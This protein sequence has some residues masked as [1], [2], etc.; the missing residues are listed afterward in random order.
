MAAEEDVDAGSDDV[1]A[2]ILDHAVA[3][4]LDEEPRPHREDRPVGRNGDAGMRA[5]AARREP[6]TSR[7]GAVGAAA[8][9][10]RAVAGG[11]DVS[12]TE[13]QMK[14]GKARRASR[15]RRKPRRL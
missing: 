7:F 6:A 1:L 10:A 4:V 11:H 8:L 9:G 5:L 15:P 14:P 12:R 13:A 2:P 3:D